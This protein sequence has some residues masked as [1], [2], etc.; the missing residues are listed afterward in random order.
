MRVIVIQKGGWNGCRPIRRTVHCG[1]AT[2]E[3]VGKNLVVEHLPSCHTT[4][5]AYPISGVLHYRMEPEHD[6][7]QG[8]CS[9]SQSGYDVLGYSF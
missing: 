4:A 1:M 3:V 6:K 8:R 5:Y 2:A 9:K 7:S